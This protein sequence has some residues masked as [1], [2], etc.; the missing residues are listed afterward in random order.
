[1]G[2]ADRHT[3]IPHFDSKYAVEQHIHS[4][5]VPATILAPVY[6]MENLTYL[7]AQ[8]RNNVYPLPLTPDRKLAQI[9]I[10]DIAAAAVTVLEHR[11]RYAGKRFDISGDEVSAN[12]IIRILSEITGRRFQHYQLPMDLV[13]QTM[14]EDVARMFE[15]FERNGYHVDREE[16]TREF[17]ELR[18]TSFEAWARAFDWDAFLS[19]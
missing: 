11:E 7:Q 13:R 14:G 17:P 4:I 3:G 10:A 5:G 1:M 8:M 6:F 2:N 9:C 19:A 15:Y 16:S 12:D 18:W